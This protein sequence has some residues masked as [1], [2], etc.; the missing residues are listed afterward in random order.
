MF[1]NILKILRGEAPARPTLFEFYL[2]QPLYEKMAGFPA[3]AGKDW[4]SDTR[5]L[6]TA[7]MK[8]G[9][10]YATVL[11]SDFYF[12]AGEVKEEKSHSLNDGACLT[13]WES[14][15]AYRWPDP[16]GF[17]YSRLDEARAHLPE[18]MKLIVWGNGGI[19]ETVIR[20]T[21][22]DNLCMMFYD[23]KALAAEIFNQVGSRFVRYYELCAGYDT[24]GALISNDDWGFNTQTMLSPDLL[25]EHVFPWHKK[26]VET[27]HAQGKPAV[28]HSCGKLDAVMEDIICAMKYDGKH[29][30]Q[31]NI[32][33]V[34]DSYKK[35]GDRIAILGG[36][37][38]DFICRNTPEHIFQRAKA[39]VELGKTGYGLGSG[40]SIPTYAPEDNYFAMTRAALGYDPREEQ[41]V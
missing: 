12:P 21:G 34:E 33:T 20:L 18:G 11:G 24:V 35:W 37:D 29:S 25:R 9:Y 30:F 15:N 7:F 22:Y 36:L 8:L 3:A 1:E 16:A 38:L 2:N 6:T 39:M 23:D 26:I 5:L 4:L 19:L 31:D 10:D 27:I 41:A 28:L 32:E 40:N 17:D 13:D 14:Y